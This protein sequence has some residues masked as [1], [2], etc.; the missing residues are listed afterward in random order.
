MIIYYHIR[1]A[2]CLCRGVWKCIK[3]WHKMQPGRELSE[4]QQDY[5]ADVIMTCIRI[6]IEG[7]HRGGD[8]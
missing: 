5:L 2:F 8:S 1:G 6:E 4:V 7:K 3:K